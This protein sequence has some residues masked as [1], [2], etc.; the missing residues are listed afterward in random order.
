MENPK[1]WYEK[2]SGEIQAGLSTGKIERLAFQFEY[3][4]TASAKQIYRLIQNCR[5]TSGNI[6]IVWFY[7]KDDEDML[8]TGEDYQDMCGFSFEFRAT[9]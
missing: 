2:L 9:G 1:E 6:N 4:N 8:E 3:F 5:E 7:D